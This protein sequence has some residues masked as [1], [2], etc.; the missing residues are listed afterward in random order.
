MM[1]GL[2]DAAGVLIVPPAGIRA[3][4]TVEA[5]GLPWTTRPV[6]SAGCL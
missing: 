5:V 1:R 4:E 3:G 2:A 6:P